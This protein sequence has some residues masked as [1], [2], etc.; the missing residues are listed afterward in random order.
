[1]KNALPYPKTFTIDA[2]KRI[3]SNVPGMQVRLYSD[4]PWRENGGPINDFEKAA[5]KRL[6]DKAKI[7]GVKLEYHQFQSRDGQ[8]L[9]SYARAQ[10]MQENCVHCHNSHKSSPKNDWK[11]GDVAGVLAITRPLDRDIERTHSGLRGAFTLVAAT[12]VVLLLL[13]LLL[14]P[15]R[16]KA[17]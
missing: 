12:A 2:G 8:Q 3:S 11:V 15:R 1:M 5:L 17:R 9:V 13:S 4:N 10:I 16:T 7:K 14:L 6:R